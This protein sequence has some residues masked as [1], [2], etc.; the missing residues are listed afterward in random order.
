MNRRSV[1]ITTRESASARIVLRLAADIRVR[2]R[3]G[4]RRPYDRG[5]ADRIRV[6]RR[7]RRPSGDD[8]AEVPIDHPDARRRSLR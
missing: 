5:V 1:P 2:Q 4:H 8:V 7:R 6:P 3:D